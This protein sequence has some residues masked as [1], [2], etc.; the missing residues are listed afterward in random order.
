MKILLY[1][2][3]FFV[4]FFCHRTCK[5][6]EFDILGKETWNFKRK[7]L[8]NLKFYTKKKSY[9]VRK[10]RLDSKTYYV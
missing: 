8:K 5:N 9:K 10:F 3:I 1:T 2:I 4:S 6:F 7:A